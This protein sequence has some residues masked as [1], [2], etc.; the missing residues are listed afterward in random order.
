MLV[1]SPESAPAPLLANSSTA[2]PPRPWARSSATSHHPVLAT[3]PAALEVSD[4]E[5]VD[6][7][8]DLNATA[9]A[10]LVKL[11]PAAGDAQ[12]S[13]AAFN[14]MCAVPARPRPSGCGCSLCQ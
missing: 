9:V 2:L 5:F 3:F 14:A 13:W 4:G 8:G 6:P 7:N 10:E 11:A 12:A 1:L